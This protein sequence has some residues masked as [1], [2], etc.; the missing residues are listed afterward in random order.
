M[1]TIPTEKTCVDI[2]ISRM[3]FYSLERLMAADCF[4]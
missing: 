4:M 1:H 3:Y 2:G